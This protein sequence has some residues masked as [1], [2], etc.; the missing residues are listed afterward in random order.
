MNYRAK[1]RRLRATNKQSLKEKLKQLSLD[2]YLIE[3]ENLDVEEALLSQIQACN[4][5]IQS[6]SKLAEERNIEGFKIEEEG[7]C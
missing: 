3:K 4:E 2:K 5:L 1:T 7:E 6:L